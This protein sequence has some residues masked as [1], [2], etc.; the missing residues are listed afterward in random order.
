MPHIELQV[1]SPPAGY[2]N[3]RSWAHSPLPSR[4]S[5]LKVAEY[6]DLLQLDVARNKKYRMDAEAA[7]DGWEMMGDQGIV[8][9]FFSM[10]VFLK[11]YKLIL[12]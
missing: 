9:F 8:T 11:V 4:S 5:S 7:A 10:F 3:T 1:E 12:F 2:K 6:I